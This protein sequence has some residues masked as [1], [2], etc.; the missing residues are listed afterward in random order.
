MRES[1]KESFDQLRAWCEKEQFKGWDPY[2]GLNSRVFQTIPLVGKSRFARLAWIQ[3]F[4]RNPVNL[5]K[6][7]L[8][9]R[10]Y[11][12][13]GLGLFLH[14]YCN[15][16]HLT[17]SESLLPRIRQLSEQVIG[18]ISP[19]Y[20][21]ACWGYNFDWQ[22]KAFFQPAGT[23]TVVASTFIGY[24]LFEAYDILEDPEIL[25][26]ATSVAEFILKDLNR[27]Y[28][29]EG[30]FAFS[31]SPLDR[32][33]VFNATLL[34]SRILA[35]TFAYTGQAELLDEAIR[36]VRF[37]MRHQREDGSWSYST[38]PYHQWIDSF[39]TG[40]N[41]ECI[42]EYQRYSG[43]FSYE[44]DLQRG[45]QYYLAH[46]FM[47]DGRCKYYNDSLYPIDIHAT[48]QLIITLIRLGVFEEHREMAEKALLWAIGN[49]QSDKG[50]FYFQIRKGMTYR[51][52]YIRWAQAWMFFALSEYLRHTGEAG[53]GGGPVNE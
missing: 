7:L 6:L 16:Y 5:R 22:A 39:H 52:P 12:P 48:A 28:D 4:K 17:R 43:D 44:R 41:L 18:K 33:Q 49:M 31:Y 27:T 9:P 47:E 38:L 8:V 1:I 36:S 11:N 46:F 24:A 53:S 42:A 32:S 37:C 40:Y 51:I 23:P 3:A 20:H 14:G 19:G 35:R 34:G 30:N 26:V 13:K 10:D 50:Y 29:E 45:F 25:S 21:G 15:L 2:D